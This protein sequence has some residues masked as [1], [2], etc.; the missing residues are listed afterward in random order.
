MSLICAFKQLSL[1]LPM[2]ADAYVLNE[3]SMQSCIDKYVDDSISTNSDMVDEAKLDCRCKNEK[4]W[5]TNRI[6]HRASQKS[7]K[8]I[9][10][11]LSYMNKPF[12]ISSTVRIGHCSKLP[13]SNELAR[14]SKNKQRLLRQQLEEQVQALESKQ[15]DLLLQVQD[16]SSYKYQLEVKCRENNSTY[17]SSF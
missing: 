12:V 17:R 11:G 1:I 4:S 9:K 13:K 16:L 14:K 6:Y 7:A 15:D 5:K 2:P 10:H 8:I 3:I